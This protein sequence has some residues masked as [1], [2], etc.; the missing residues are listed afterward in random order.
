MGGHAC[1]CGLP[2]PSFPSSPSP[3]QKTMPFC[4]R[5]IAKSSPH[6]ICCRKVREVTGVVGRRATGDRVVK[7]MVVAVMVVA[8]RVVAGV[9][10]NTCV[11][12][13]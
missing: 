11:N 5:A 4:I 10:E 6:S 8:V 2:S 1:D 13:F 9:C 12:L 7:A 3:Q